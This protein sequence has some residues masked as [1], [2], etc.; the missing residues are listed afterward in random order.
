[1]TSRAWLAQGPVTHRRAVLILIA[2]T[3]IW[4]ASFTLNKMVLAAVSPLLMMGIRFTLAAA[5]LAP[6]FRDASRD[7]WKVGLGLGGL[8]AVQLALFI[9]GLEH[10]PSNRAGFLFGVS[11]PLVPAIVLLVSRQRPSPRDLAAVALALLGTW[12]LTGPSAAGGLGK[13]DLLM[14]GSAACGAGYVVAAG[15]WAPRHEPFPLLAVQVVVL[16]ATGLGL[17]LLIESPRLEPDPGILLLIAF[18]ALSSVATFGGQLVGQRMVR[19]TEAALVYAL[20]PVVAAAAGYVALGEAL[21]S[22]QWLGAGLI[23]IAAFVVRP[24]PGA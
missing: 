21:R 5:M 11:T 4:G 6:A 23:L 15:H 1:V 20:E 7:D 10:I 16:A 24:R 18:L 9:T 13:G 19:P 14:L 22:W 2:C 3:A 12:W 8:F 17:A